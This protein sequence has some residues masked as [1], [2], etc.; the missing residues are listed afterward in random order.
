MMN[1]GLF[2]QGLLAS[3][4]LGAPGVR[5]QDPYPALRPEA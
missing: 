4:V 5:A 1:R 3:S 2:T